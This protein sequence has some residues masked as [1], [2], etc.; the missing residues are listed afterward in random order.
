ME[1]AKSKKADSWKLLEFQAQ[2]QEIWVSWRGCKG[3][4]F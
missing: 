1:T 4:T 3:Y 2:G